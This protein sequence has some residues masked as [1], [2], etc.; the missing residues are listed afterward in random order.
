[1]HD[2]RA[3]L[4]AIIR[5]DPDLMRLLRVLRWL[6]LPQGR[7]VAGAIYQT[8]WNVLSG[9]PRGTGIR[10]YD[11]VYFDEGDLSYEA[12][13]VVIRRVAAATSDFK[14]KVETRNQARVHLWYEQRFGAPYPPLACADQALLRYSTITHA[15]GVRLE[16]DGSLDVIAPFGLDDMFDMIIR[17]NPACP[18]TT[19][20]D[21][22]AERAKATWPRLRAIG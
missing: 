21:E 19:A 18:S 20:H 17:R 15:V 8:V 16:A 6:D 4:E 12:E 9:F 11:V 3:E 2:R 7:A 10:D 1:M 22:K 14:V 13:D 5:A